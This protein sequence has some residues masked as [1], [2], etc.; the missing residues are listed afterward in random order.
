MSMSLLSEWT[1]S[2]KDIRTS[3]IGTKKIASSKINIAKTKAMCNRFKE[4]RLLAVMARVLYRSLQ[5]HLSTNMYT[6]YIYA[7]KKNIGI[8]Y[9]AT[10]SVPFRCYFG[11]RSELFD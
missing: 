9:I 5:L 4:M 8:G 1:K 2:S 11:C 10:C 6:Y 3:G 7:T